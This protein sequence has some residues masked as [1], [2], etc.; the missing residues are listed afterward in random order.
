M[1]IEYPRPTSAA[2]SAVMRANRKT[3]TAPEVTIRA[4]VHRRGMRFRKHLSVRVS[5]L[6]VRPDIVFTRQRVAVF[7]DGC[8]WHCCPVHGN[9]PQ[10][11]SRYWEAK[12]ARNRARD[13][14]VNAALEAEGW[15]VL[16]VWEHERPDEAADVISAVVSGGG[17]ALG[18]G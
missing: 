12:L 8:F 1:R 14:A 18:S 3:D 15:V 5:N 7:I 13:A 4:A 10:S 6:S 16:R 9:R 11:N 17:P 2:V